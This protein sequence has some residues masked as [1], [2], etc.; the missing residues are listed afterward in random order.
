MILAFNL[1]CSHI[2]SNFCITYFLLISERKYSF[3]ILTHLENKNEIEEKYID[4]L[5]NRYLKVLDTTWFKK[6]S[7]EKLADK[8]KEIGSVSKISI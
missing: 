3:D 8:V 1:I 6:S 4:L 7:W 5:V 2:C